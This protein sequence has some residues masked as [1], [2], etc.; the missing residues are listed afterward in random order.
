[1]SPTPPD[2]NYAHG[3]AR[4][5]FTDS[6]PPAG[7]GHRPADCNATAS[8][9]RTADCSSGQFEA[10]GRPQ[11]DGP[12]D[13][14]EGASAEAG[15]CTTGS[16]KSGP[17]GTRPLQ[18]LLPLRVGASLRGDG[19]QR[20]TPGLR[21]PGGGGVQAGAGCRSQLGPAGRWTGRSLLQDRADQGRGE[22]RAGSVEEEPGRCGGPHPAGAGL[23]AFA[24]RHAGHTG[25]RDATVGNRRVRDHL[26]P[27]A[28][29][30]WKPSCCSVSSMR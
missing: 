26:A 7:V 8:G 22:R 17:D 20:R 4:S 19:D 25:G 5:S 28:C 9:R 15:F 23:S 12:T 3:L 1:M 18:R 13:A 2:R 14:A 27:E 24:G 29:A 16:R 11:A 21:D 6:S 10:A 30:T